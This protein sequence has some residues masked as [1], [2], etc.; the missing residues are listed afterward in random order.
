M[1]ICAFAAIRKENKVLL[2]RIAPPFAEARKWNFPG[3]V[4][5]DSEDIR[6][7]LIREVTEETGV[8][9]SVGAI[10]DNFT[11]T[12]PGND[13][14]IFDAVYLQGKIVIQEEEILEAQW[15]TIQEA[16]ALELAFNIDKYIRCL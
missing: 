12:N 5:E 4:I 16:L 8:V 6:A 3:G 1:A 2:V 13:I 10:R 15:F 14:T 11:I 7:G 9:C